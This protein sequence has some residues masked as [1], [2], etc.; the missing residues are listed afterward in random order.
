MLSA[1]PS[2]RSQTQ[3][4]LQRAWSQQYQAAVGR[5]PTPRLSTTIELLP[6]RRYGPLVDGKQ[7]ENN[8]LLRATVHGAPLIVERVR[9]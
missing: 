1:S 2:G 7:D 6:R 5:C 8:F 9:R 4:L 3:V